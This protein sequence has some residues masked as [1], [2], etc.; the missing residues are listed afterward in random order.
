MGGVAEKVFAMLKGGG[1]PK[2]LGSFLHSR[3]KL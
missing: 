2:V 1:G 3:L